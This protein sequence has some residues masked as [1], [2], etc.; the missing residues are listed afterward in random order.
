MEAST[1]K[2]QDIQLTH[3]NMMHQSTKRSD[4]TQGGKRKRSEQPK[5]QERDKP[6]D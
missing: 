6:V 5:G 2:L 4:P 1:K 3:V